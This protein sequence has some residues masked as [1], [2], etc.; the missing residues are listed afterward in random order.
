MC[1]DYSPRSE[2][3]P[4]N[5]PGTGDRFHRRSDLLPVALPVRALELVIRKKVRNAGFLF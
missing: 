5:R 1:E 2:L 3:L 4:Q